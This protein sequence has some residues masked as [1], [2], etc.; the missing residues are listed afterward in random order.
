MELSEIL[1]GIAYKIAHKYIYSQISN[2]LRFTI[3]QDAALK[4]KELT[5]LDVKVVVSF[6][7]DEVNLD[8]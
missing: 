1:S 5:G 3:E 7:S 8:S 6:G 4:V 2:E